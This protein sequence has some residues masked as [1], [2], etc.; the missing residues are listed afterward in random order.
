MLNHI[1]ISKNF[2][3]NEFQCKGKN[4]CNNL[5]KIDSEIIELLQKLRN[6]INKAIIVTSGYR[7]QIHNKEVED[8]PNSY[9]L[10][11]LAVDVTV[12]KFN[13]RELARL[14]KM[15]GFSTVITYPHRKFI[16]LDIRKKG[17]GLIGV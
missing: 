2:Y 6:E 11:G 16:H 1:K 14:A 12:T 13:I 4:C 17:L 3:L 5:V 9:H 8:Q 15:V 10:S 7:C